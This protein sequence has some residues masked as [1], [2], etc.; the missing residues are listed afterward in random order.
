MN[1]WIK[2]I[3]VG[4]A[5]GVLAI[6]LFLGLVLIALALAF[7]VYAQEIPSLPKTLCTQEPDWWSIRQPTAEELAEHGRG[8]LVF[9]YFNSSHRCSENQ[10]VGVYFGELRF[11]MT[12]VVDH[13][14][15]LGEYVMIDTSGTPY[16]TYSRGLVL[17][18]GGE[19]QTIILYPA[20]Y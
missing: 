4:M 12:V 16:T 9:E 3:L 5:L 14:E 6:L 17:E 19:P 18:D 15:R 13:A 2:Q 1:D 7:P 10:T 8:I 11:E 20:V